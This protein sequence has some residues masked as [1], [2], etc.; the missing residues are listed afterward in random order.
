[1]QALDLPELRAALQGEDGP[2]WMSCDEWLCHFHVPVDLE[3]VGERLSTTRA[4]SDAYL[5]ALLADPAR[6]T[7]NQLHVE[8]ET[9]TWDV[10][11]GAAKAAGALVDGLAR[12]YAHV[13]SELASAG[14]I[15]A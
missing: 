9:Y 4:Q 3:G 10:L 5:K 15:T 8:I 13:V 14:W 11:P 2:H 7:T 6:W 12:E 1:M